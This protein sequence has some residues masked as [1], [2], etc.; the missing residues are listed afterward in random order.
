MTGPSGNRVL[1]PLDLNVPLGFGTLGVSGKQNSLFPLWP[2]LI[3]YTQVRLVNL[4][5]SLIP[6]KL[7]KILKEIFTLIPTVLLSG[8]TFI[9]E[10]MGYAF[11]HKKEP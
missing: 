2:V 8:V 7:Q 5:F 11:A 1:F 9:V 6:K 3:K 4:R 10:E